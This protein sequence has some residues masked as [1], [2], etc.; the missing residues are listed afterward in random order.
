MSLPVR[1]AA[2][3]VNCR[4]NCKQ[5]GSKLFQGFCVRALLKKVAY[6]SQTRQ[7]ENWPVCGCLPRSKIVV[8]F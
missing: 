3:F 1:A 6:P 8:V 7:I 5:K 4:T 2:I